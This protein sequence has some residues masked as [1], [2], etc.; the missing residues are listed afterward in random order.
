MAGVG[1]GRERS[2]EHPHS[3]M[4]RHPCDGCLGQPVNGMVG[5]PVIG[6]PVLSDF[7]AHRP[8]PISAKRCKRIVRKPTLRAWAYMTGVPLHMITDP[9]ADPRSIEAQA[10]GVAGRATA[11]VNRRGSKGARLMRRYLRESDSCCE[12]VSDPLALQT[13]RGARRASSEHPVA[14]V[15]A[16]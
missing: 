8:L 7:R 5:C 9:I 1:K 15:V 13:D 14:L 2:L 12:G 4:S 10:D 11:G 3:D 6:R 16:G